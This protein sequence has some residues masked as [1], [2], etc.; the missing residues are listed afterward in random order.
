MQE[1]G[2]SPGT[3][4]D[5]LLTDRTAMVT[6]AGASVGRKIA[7]T[8]A[9]RRYYVVSADRDGGQAAE[10]V[11]NEIA[12]AGIKLIGAGRRPFDHFAS[13]AYS[14]GRAEEGSSRSSAR[15]SPSTPASFRRSE[16]RKSRRHIS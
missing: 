4:Q 5:Q 16:A 11:Q 3:R 10:A 6:G 9:S 7:L 13:H 2:A 15:T 14:V 12:S 1:A 8:F